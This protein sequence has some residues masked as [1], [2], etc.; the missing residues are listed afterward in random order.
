MGADPVGT[1]GGRRATGLAGGGAEGLAPPRPLLDRQRAVVLRRS[2]SPRT[3]WRS[4]AG[5]QRRRRERVSA[6]G[7]REEAGGERGWP[8]HLRL[9][10]RRAEARAA[11]NQAGEKTSR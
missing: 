9:P 8:Q 10:H 3:H 4:R 5:Q 2:L 1:D 7:R 11:G 6:M